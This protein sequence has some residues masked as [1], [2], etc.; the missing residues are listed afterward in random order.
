MT[1]TNGK[2]SCTHFIG[3]ALQQLNQPCGIIGTLGNGLYGNIIPGYLTT[4]DAITLQ[5]ILADFRDQ[6]IKTVAMEVSSHSIDQGRIN[7]IDFEIGLFTNL[8]RDHLDYHG[9]MEA[10]A[11]VKKKFFEH[12]FLRHAVINLDDRV[13]REIAGAISNKKNSLSP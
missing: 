13:G 6:K 7:G 3:S 10:Y 2:T 9:T 1:G 11:G 8:T 12:T 5:K 4:P